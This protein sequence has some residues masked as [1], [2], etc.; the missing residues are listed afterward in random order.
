MGPIEKGDHAARL[1][2]D[3]FVQELLEEIRREYCREWEEAQSPQSREALWNEL[4]GLKRFTRTL[5]RLKDGRTRALAEK[6][7][8]D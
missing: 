1:L 3:S 2:E 6:P 4:Q 7:K 5:R 8:G